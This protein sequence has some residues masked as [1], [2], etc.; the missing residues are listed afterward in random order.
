LLG[1]AARIPQGRGIALKRRVH[2]GAT[3]SA[4]LHDQ[5]GNEVELVYELPR[6]L[7]EDDIDGA[8]N[9]AVTQ[10]LTA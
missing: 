9:T 3:W 1:G 5:D 8:L 10:P 2:R 6:V 7:W 4:H